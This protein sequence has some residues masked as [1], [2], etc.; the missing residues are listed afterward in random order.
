MDQKERKEEL[1]VY[2]L[3]KGLKQG[4]FMAFRPGLEQIK[5]GGGKR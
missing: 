2:R 3:K 1:G 4:A 5:P